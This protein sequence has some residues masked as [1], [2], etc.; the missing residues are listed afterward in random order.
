MTISWGLFASIVGIGGGI[1]YIQILMNLGYPPFAA[2]STS[3]FIVMYSAAANSISYFI[4]GKLNI[5]N[6]L[7]LALWTTVGVII[8]IFGANRLI[9]KTGRE[10]IFI[11]VLALLL[12]LSIVSIIVFDLI[13]FVDDIADGEV[14]FNA[15]D[16]CK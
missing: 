1:F 3:M 4:S 16:F 9:Q 11:F 8:R 5:T 12:A 7:W 6:G 14:K 15:I 13:E 2:S 10:S